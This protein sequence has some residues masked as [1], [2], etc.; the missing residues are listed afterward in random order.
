MTVVHCVKTLKAEPSAVPCE[1]IRVR[2]FNSVT[3]IDPWLMVRNAAFAR[4]RVGVR[5]WSRADFEE[6]I[7]RKPWW[8]PER[9]WLAETQERDEV[10]QVAGTVTLAFRAG[11]DRE[12]PV[13]HWL[14]VHPRF[15]RR[16]IGR[17]LMA[18][19]ERYCWEHGWVEI[20]LETHTAWA[21][22]MAL[23]ESLGYV[24]IP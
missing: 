11:K 1:G 24:R 4:E 3:D 21:K 12:L 9:T 15:R 22:A 2:T 16:G 10:P 19:L 14:A 5:H 17:T 8:L 6:E 20:G 7:V 18:V 23:Y 13:V